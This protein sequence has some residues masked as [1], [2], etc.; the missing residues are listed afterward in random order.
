[1]PKKI[2]ADDWHAEASTY[3]LL[4]YMLIAEGDKS[5]WVLEDDR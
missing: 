3:F 2:E 4:G 5:Y 1:M